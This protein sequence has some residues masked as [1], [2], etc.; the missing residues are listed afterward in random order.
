MKK[1]FLVLVF[2]SQISFGFACEDSRVSCKKRISSLESQKFIERRAL[3]E[4]QFVGLPIANVVVCDSS[5]P[6]YFPAEFHFIRSI[7]GVGESIEIEDG[8]VWKLSENNMRILSWKN[9]DPLIITQN[10]SWFSDYSYVIVNK[11]TGESV[12][13]TLDL[14]PLEDSQWL[15]KVQFVNVS[16]SEIIL[17]NQ[18]KWKVSS[19]D[20]DL[21]K[22]WKSGDVVIIGTNTSQFSFK[23]NL[24]I[25]VSMNEYIRVSPREMK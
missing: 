9:T 13:A 8:S 17:D 15:K 22:E 18:T 2:F 21:I 1:W 24:L 10:H 25:N 4:I 7:S 16:R 23:K 6:C 20:R 12:L 11:Y 14:G 19:W 3:K 5:T